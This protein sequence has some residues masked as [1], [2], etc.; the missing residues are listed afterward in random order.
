NT[1]IAKDL[2]LHNIW[3]NQFT[4]L[5][6]H[7]VDG[8]SN[9]ILGA[10]FG[11]EPM[12]TWSNIVFA[13]DDWRTNGN[14]QSIDPNGL[15]VTGAFVQSLKAS[16]QANFVGSAHDSVHAW[17]FGTIDQHATSDGDGIAIP[18]S[19]YDHSAALPARSVSGFDFS[20]IAGGRRPASGIA[21]A[22]GGT[23][24]RIDPGQR[25]TQ[26]ADVGDI[27]LRSTAVSA[28]SSVKIQFSE[29][30][31]QSASKITFYLDTDQNPYDGNTVR[32]LARGMFA[33]ANSITAEHLKAGTSGVS[34]GTYFVYAKITAADGLVRYE[35]APQKITVIR[36]A[37][38][39]RAVT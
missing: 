3:V 31:R 23:A 38:S 29:Q 16:V 27:V 20:L 36:S 39:D 17:Y 2:G 26:W 21:S 33:Q 34:P 37:S 6:P 4:S 18:A 15:P 24:A 5:D 7:P 19:W 10:N 32:T 13:D 14:G 30:D 11:D 1:E 28:G 35:Y 8:G 22:H 9:N 25:G 12:K